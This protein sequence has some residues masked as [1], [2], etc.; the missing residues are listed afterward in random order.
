MLALCLTQI[1]DQESPDERQLR[2][3]SPINLK[4]ISI[5]PGFS[6]AARPDGLAMSYVAPHQAMAT[7]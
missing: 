3:T 5:W 6:L 1:M 4:K 2:L 7:T